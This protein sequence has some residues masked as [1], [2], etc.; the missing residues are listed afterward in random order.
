[1]ED[2]KGFDMKKDVDKR[3]IDKKGGAACGYHSWEW[4]DAAYASYCR[5]HFK[6][7]SGIDECSVR[8]SGGEA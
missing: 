4:V 6:P 3:D 2:K 8:A 5:Y 7:G 1:M